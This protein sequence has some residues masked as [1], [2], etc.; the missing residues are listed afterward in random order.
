MKAETLLFLRASFVA[1]LLSMA[2]PQ[3]AVAH[4][5]GKEI[6]HAK[7]CKLIASK[8]KYKKCLACMKTKTNR[9][10]HP[11]RL[12]GR[13]MRNGNKPFFRKGPPN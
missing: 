10:Y 3:T 6:R 5:T 13:C 8:K 12:F 7:G 4:K 2:W 1:T 9:H 11:Y